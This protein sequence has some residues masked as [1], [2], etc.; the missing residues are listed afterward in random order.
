[1][2]SAKLYGAEIRSKEVIFEPGKHRTGQF[3]AD[4]RTAGSI[5]LLLQ[6][7]LPCAVFGS[8]YEFESVIKLV[9]GTNASKAPQIDYFMHVFGEIVQR[10]GISF[11]L[12]LVKRGYYP[13]GKGLAF[14]RCKSLAQGKTLEPLLIERQGDLK[15]VT[16]YAHHAG[17]TPREHTK[18]AVKTAKEILED[19]FLELKVKT[20][21]KSEN[22]EEAFGDGGGITIVARTSTGCILA[23]SA[24]WTQDMDGYSMGSEAA[25]QLIRNVEWGGCLDEFAQDQIIIFMALAQG[26]S[27]VKV[28]PLQ[29]HTETSIH[30]ATLLT[31]AKFTVNEV[32]P[33]EY[34]RPNTE[35]SFFI[36]CDGIGFSS[37]SMISSHK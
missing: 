12:R 20:E 8:N 7:A 35:R 15:Q 21:L 11:D 31:G 1:M 26:H 10:F 28:G 4:T 24:L 25:N 23:G 17:D 22:E 36:E 18:N 37:P 33:S 27:R 32:P 34:E 6:V 3:V 9:G 2:Y 16:I 5:C 19:Q 13:K 30:F 29:L 14:F